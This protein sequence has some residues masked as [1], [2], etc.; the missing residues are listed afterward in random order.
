M[1]LAIRFG[2]MLLTA[3]LAAGCSNQVEVGP[4][5]GLDSRMGDPGTSGATGGGGAGSSPADA[6]NSATNWQ[7]RQLF[8]DASESP[9]PFAEALNA[10]LES[11]TISSISVS[12]YMA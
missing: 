6:C 3:A 11:Q 2:R 10:L 4:T 8:F 12:N 1:Q 9:R 7:A 5:A